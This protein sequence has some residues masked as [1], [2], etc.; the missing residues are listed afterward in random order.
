MIGVVGETEF[1]AGYESLLDGGSP[2]LLGRQALA[3]VA[4]LAYSFVLTFALAHVLKALMGL[5]VP[6]QDEVTGVDQTLHAETAYDLAGIGGG[7][8]PGVPAGLPTVR[9]RV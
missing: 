8:A 3:A 4:V 5:R 9:K 7:T 6:D 2:A 1:A